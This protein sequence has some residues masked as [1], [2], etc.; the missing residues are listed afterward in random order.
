MKEKKKFFTVQELAKTVGVSTSALRAW[1]RRYSLFSPERTEGGHRLYTQDDLKLFW[2][3]SHLREQGQDLK[4]IASLGRELLS[5]RAENFFRLR[6]RYESNTTDRPPY[7]DILTALINCDFETAIGGLERFYALATDARGFADLALELMVYVGDSWHSGELSIAAEHAM[8]QRV[9][10]LLLGLLYS[11]HLSPQELAQQPS[12]VLSTLPEEQHELGLLRVAIY[13]KHWGWKVDYLG[14]DTPLAALDDCVR[15]TK[16]SLV[17]VS[18]TQVMHPLTLM[19]NLCKLNMLIGHKTVICAGG[20][21][22]R[23]LVKRHPE[24][25]NVLLCES[26]DELKEITAKLAI[27]APNTLET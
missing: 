9:K 17:C 14:A 15:R 21:G 19:T 8:T 13:L 6:S 23:P 11:S 24:L 27:R 5:Q 1:E 26:V 7:T 2:Y 20:T 3:I 25:G 10:H 18:V 22:V 16:P 12:V 4:D